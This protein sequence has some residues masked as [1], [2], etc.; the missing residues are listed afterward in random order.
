MD[1]AAPALTPGTEAPLRLRRRAIAVVSVATLVAACA[2]F[3]AAR[4]NW[5]TAVHERGRAVET[6]NAQRA[7]HR[8]SLESAEYT[9]AYVR[10]AEV[11]LHVG[12]VDATP[13]TT[14]EA[15]EALARARA[16]WVEAA[17]DYDAAHALSA[18][19]AL[20]RGYR[21]VV[22]SQQVADDHA[23]LAQAWSSRESENLGVAGLSAVALLL[24]ATALTLPASKRPERFLVLAACVVAYSVVRIGYVNAH[25]PAGLSREAIAAFADG[26]V[27]D[28]LGDTPSAVDAFTRTVRREPRYAAAWE[29]LGSVYLKS[30]DARAPRW[31]ADSY[32]RAVE[33]GAH[34]G[35]LLN[36]LA[37]AELLAGD[38]ARAAT[39]A[40]AAV[41]LL[42]G[43]L[44]VRA[45]AAEVLVAQGDERAAMAAAGELVAAV[46]GETAT[47]R[48]QM[49]AAWRAD[50]LELEEAG[51]GAAVR[52]EF[53]AELR[54]AGATLSAFG[55]PYPRSAHGAALVRSSF[56]YEH[57]AL[58][59]H[60][61]LTFRGLHAEDQIGIR[62]YDGA[63]LVLTKDRP[64]RP[65][66]RVAGSLPVDRAEYTVEVYVNGVIAGTAT[67]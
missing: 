26:A 55:D 56:G 17:R 32:S 61:D 64:G 36:N 66:G 38:T 23:L 43:D 40:A 67:T 30:A 28:R 60:Y 3:L 41:E 21:P 5:R 7:L 58:R 11:V 12:A 39:H 29:A 1:P 51:I 59:L 31:A 8:L 48:D 63:T 10:Q 52:D 22:V 62:V 33:L 15:R 27:F 37:Y 16:H 4:A 54:R 14:A 35:A 19:E 50:A 46:T 20:A 53:F 18:D 57:E 24:V 13:R 34:S 47:L 65:D 9:D 49:F 45:T 25:D 42:P 44:T 2:G 6:A